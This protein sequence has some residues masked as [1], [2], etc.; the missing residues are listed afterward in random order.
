MGGKIRDKGS[1]DLGRRRSN[2]DE[3]TDGNNTNGVVVPVA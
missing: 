1:M 3:F 2:I